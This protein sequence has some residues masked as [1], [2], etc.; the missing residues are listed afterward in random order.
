MTTLTITDPKT[1]KTFTAEAISREEYL[2]KRAAWKASYAKLS[3]DIRET[4]L[5]IKAAQRA[6]EHD[7]ISGLTMTREI[8][9]DYANA[10]LEERRI[11]KLVAQASYEHMKQ[12]ERLAA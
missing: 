2:A 1:E 8:L 12:E 7:K 11:M 3:K 10:A 6:N 4:K 9:R 5:E